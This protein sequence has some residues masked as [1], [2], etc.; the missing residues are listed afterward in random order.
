VKLFENRDSRCDFYYLDHLH[1]L[2]K[3]F[4]DSMLLKIIS[5]NLKLVETGPMRERDPNELLI[6]FHHREY[7]DEDN[8]NGCNHMPYDANCGTLGGEWVE[9][10]KSCSVEIAEDGRLLTTCPITIDSCK[11]SAYIPPVPPEPK[12]CTFLGMEAECFN[13]PD[14]PAQPTEIDLQFQINSKER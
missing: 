9:V 1:R 5:K 12:K 8:Y 11:V 3:Q 13:H 7:N 10:M 4:P 2:L 6:N 14:E